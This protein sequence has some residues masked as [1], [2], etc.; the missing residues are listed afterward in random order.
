VAAYG[1]RRVVA[2]RLAYTRYDRVVEGLGGHGEYVER[3][4]ELRPRWSAPSPAGAGAG[5]V[6]IGSSD[7]RKDALSL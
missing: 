6:K 1:D 7:F 3:L 5:H 4:A 2:T